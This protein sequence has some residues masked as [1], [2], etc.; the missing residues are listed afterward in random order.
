MKN[1]QNL[2]YVLQNVGTSGRI[3]TGGVCDRSVIIMS[4]FSSINI[5]IIN[6]SLWSLCMLA[7]KQ[8]ME[9]VQRLFYLFQ[10]KRRGYSLRVYYSDIAFI[11]SPAAV[12]G[13]SRASPAVASGSGPSAAK[14]LEFSNCCCCHTTAATETLGPVSQGQLST[15][16]KQNPNLS[17]FR[18]R[19]CGVN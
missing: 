12:S 18:N 3:R 10:L 17:K 8:V 9:T 5:V 19:R 4:I 16:F 14:K 11:P 1:K 15:Y 2:K 13:A 6:P 7:Y